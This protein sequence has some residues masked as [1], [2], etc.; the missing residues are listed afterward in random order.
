MKIDWLELEP[1]DPSMQER[2][3]QIETVLKDLEESD[4]SVSID[5]NGDRLTIA[6]KEENGTTRVFENQII[7]AGVI[8]RVLN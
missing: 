8:G 5:L 2:E 4:T 7:R 6:I 1:T 3:T